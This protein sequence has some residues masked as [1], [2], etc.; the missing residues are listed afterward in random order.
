MQGQSTEWMMAV[1]R[2]LREG[3]EKAV[4]DA[5]VGQMVSA[6]L[7]LNATEGSTYYDATQLAIQQRVNFKIENLQDPNSAESKAVEEYRNSIGNVESS[8]PMSDQEVLERIIEQ[9][10]KFVEMQKNFQT[11]FCFLA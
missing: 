5:R 10:N 1:D 7:S 6:I 3:D 11:A 8:T 2:A 4:H 9:A